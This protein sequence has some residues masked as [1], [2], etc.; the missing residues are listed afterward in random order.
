[1]KLKQQIYNAM[2]VC[3]SAQTWNY[4]YNVL[5]ISKILQYNK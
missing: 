4:V 2:F 5:D 3:F 1:M